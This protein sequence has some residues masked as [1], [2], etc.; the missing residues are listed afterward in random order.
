MTALRPVTPPPEPEPSPPRVGIEADAQLIREWLFS[1]MND[2]DARLGVMM[3]QAFGVPATSRLGAVLGGVGEALVRFLVPLLAGL[4]AGDLGQSPVGTWVL[5]TGLL[6]TV[7]VATNLHSQNTELQSGLF[8]LVDTL[9]HE[10]DA[11]DLLAFTRRRW[12][13]GITAVFGAGVSVTSLVVIAGTAPAAFGALPVGSVA[14]LGILA[15]GLGDIAYLYL[16]F[17][18]G[19]LAR[20][21]RAEHR[22]FWLSPLDSEPVRRTLQASGSAVGVVGL[23]VTLYI[24]LSAL[25]VGLDS[26]LVLP[27]VA[28]FTAVGYLAVGTALVSIRRN[29][30]ALTRGVRDRHLAVLQDRIEGYGHRLGALSPAENDELRHL[31]ETYRSVRD[32]PTKPSASESFGQ[33]ARALL[34]PTLG[35]FL[36]VLSEVYAERLLDQVLP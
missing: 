34:I 29:V 9:E 10:R 22:L 19:F 13:I 36:A 18:P 25:A 16:S 28:T 5:I 23:A 3:S 7:H 33:A 17:M 35:F 20:V 26:P 2:A 8:A 1:P 30:R 11:H 21:G 32:A 4:F 15:F 24:V 31:V 27:V 14:L 6:G 12:R